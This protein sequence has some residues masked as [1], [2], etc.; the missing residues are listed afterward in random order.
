MVELPSDKLSG[1][2]K[3]L[4]LTGFCIGADLAKED[5]RTLI[6]D[7]LKIFTEGFAQG[8]ETLTAIL[9]DDKIKKRKK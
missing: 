5:K 8:N 2:K 7:D 6:G 1:Y 3:T 4:W 9:H